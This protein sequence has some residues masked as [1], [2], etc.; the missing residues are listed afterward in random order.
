MICS[1][2]HISSTTPNGEWSQ[3]ETEMIIYDVDRSLNIKK[4]IVYY[5]LLVDKE[6]HFIDIH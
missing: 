6:E 5:Y 2:Y 1:W 4:H 3:R